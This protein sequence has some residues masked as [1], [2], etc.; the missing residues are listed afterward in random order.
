[1]CTSQQSEV[2]HCAWILLVLKI[3]LNT[4]FRIPRQALTSVDGG[5]RPIFYGLTDSFVLQ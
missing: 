2:R 5:G 4:S 1:M 3:K